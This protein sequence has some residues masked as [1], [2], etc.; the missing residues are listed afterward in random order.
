ML[1]VWYAMLN[2]IEKPCRYRG[3][4][5]IA[6]DLVKAQINVLVFT[7]VHVN[8]SRFSAVAFS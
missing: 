8:S 2:V 3:Q 7:G 6:V 4:T 5:K 1:L